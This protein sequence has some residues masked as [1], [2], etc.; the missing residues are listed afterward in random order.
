MNCS[1]VACGVVMVFIVLLC[2]CVVVCFAGVV[3]LIIPRMQMMINAARKIFQK[4]EESLGGRMNS[5]LE[6]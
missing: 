4:S 2:G 6:A 5:E 1:R 3:P